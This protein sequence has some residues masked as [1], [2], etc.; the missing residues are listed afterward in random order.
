MSEALAVLFLLIFMLKSSQRH[1]ANTQ[2]N[3]SA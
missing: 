3:E 1:F 2:E